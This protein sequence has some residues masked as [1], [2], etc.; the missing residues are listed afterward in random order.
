MTALGL[1]S[2]ATV[3]LAFLA[4]AF[5]AYLRGITGF[6]FGIAAVPLLSVI[7]APAEAV[8]VVLVLQLFVGLGSLPACHRHADWRSIGLLAASAV[9]VTPAGI[10]LLTVLPA[11]GS[12]LII[13]IL[14]CLA[15]IV[16][17]SGFALRRM[18]GIPATLGIGIVSGLCNGVAAMPGPPVILFY[19]SSPL[20]VAASRASMIIFFIF[21]AIAAL[22]VAVPAHLVT[23]HILLLTAILMPALALGSYLSERQFG[24]MAASSYR[25]LALSSLLA[26]GVLA[27]GRAAQGFLHFP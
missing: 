10:Y 18:P 9:L 7:L 25:T 2:P 23:L 1:L 26:I 15:V 13:S 4:I 27:A 21:S 8:P 19:L 3:L 6:G 17:W 12:R 16:L 14:V 20:E 11:N 24:R 5:S 22:A